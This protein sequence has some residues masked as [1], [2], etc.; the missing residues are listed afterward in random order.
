MLLGLSV[1]CLALAMERR[2]YAYIDPGSSLVIFQG[3]GAALSAGLF[4][5]RKRLL[6]L[7]KRS[8]EGASDGPVAERS[9]TQSVTRSGTRPVEPSLTAKKVE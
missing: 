7:F 3:V 1:V 9:V 2:A 6:G 8:G 4:Y 5:F